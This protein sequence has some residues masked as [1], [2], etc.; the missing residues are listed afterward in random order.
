MRQL[1][2][3]DIQRKLAQI[4]TSGRSRKWKKRA[5]EHLLEDVGAVPVPNAKGSYKTQ[6]G[7]VCA[8]RR[9][10][11]ASAATQALVDTFMSPSPNRHECRIYFCKNCQGFHLTSHR[12]KFDQEQ[13]DDC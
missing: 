5:R 4:S 13:D 2:P 7:D 3:G 6:R 1:S 12:N 10:S 8:K 9:F 11:K